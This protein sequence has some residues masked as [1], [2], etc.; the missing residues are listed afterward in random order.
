MATN[1]ES[2]FQKSDGQGLFA[3]HVVA[4]GIDESYKN[5]LAQTPIYL[6][7]VLMN[8]EH[9]RKL[10]S[11][12]IL[13]V[14]SL[15]PLNTFAVTF[16]L[17][18]T[19]VVTVPSRQGLIVA[20]DSRGNFGPAGHCD[21]I[22]KIIEPI[23]PERIAVSVVGNAQFFDAPES[24]V[25]LCEYIHRVQPRLDVQQLARDYL[26]TETADDSTL[27]MEGFASQCAAAVQKYYDSSPAT[28][29]PYAG[30]R[31]FSVV[32]MGYDLKAR[33]AVIRDFFLGLSSD[34]VKLQVGKIRSRK[35]SV[36]SK[37]E[38]FLFGE[39]GY[40]NTRVLNG[41]GR[42]FLNQETIRFIQQ[43]KKVADIDFKEA[44]A[45]A[46]NLIDA[47]SKTT[48]LVPA[49]GIGGPIYILLLGSEPRPRRIQ[50]G[51]EENV[52]Q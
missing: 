13:V 6:H 18:G 37:G 26:E 47:A 20:A 45:V 19:L 25:D 11:S 17:N 2:L 24:N 39:S 22:I 27:R 42:Q 5:I 40:F 31:L 30:R 50:W 7:V 10:F 34:P 33:T 1:R 44:L 8:R 32:M 4:K 41:I 15:N 36:E 21:N 14:F 3:S 16:P 49:K 46:K 28:L 29:K 12:T 48:A 52:P 51:K 9:V 38:V 43:K 23:K 35:L